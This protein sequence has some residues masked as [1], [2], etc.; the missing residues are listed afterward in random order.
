MA[1][2]KSRFTLKS[3]S[4][5]IKSSS[6]RVAEEAVGQTVRVVVVVVSSIISFEI[7]CPL[8][9]KIIKIKI[10]KYSKKF[11]LGKTACFITVKRQNYLFVEEID[12]SNSSKSE[13][14]D[15]RVGM[16]LVFV[17]LE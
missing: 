16:T 17:E 10:L 9:L 4:E 7:N 3:D 1:L 14:T 6:S 12:V 13:S 11:K 8:L 5:A 2:L 15:G